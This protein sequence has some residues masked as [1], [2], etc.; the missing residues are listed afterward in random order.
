MTKRVKKKFFI[1]LSLLLT[2]VLLI[3]MVGCNT[4][5]KEPFKAD[6]KI[7]VV[8][9]NDEPIV[10][11]FVSVMNVNNTDLPIG[12]TTDSNG[13]FIL[14][15]LTEREL[16][17]VIHGEEASYNTKYTISKTDLEQG[18]ITVRFSDIIETTIAKPAE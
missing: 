7:T 9:A 15:N 11:T 13:Q 10:D 8:N 18:S 16:T 17:F 12:Y 14:K 3:S 1:P 6:V 4:D 5:E 2:V